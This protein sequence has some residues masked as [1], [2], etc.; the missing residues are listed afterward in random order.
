SFQVPDARGRWAA[1]EIGFFI[2]GP[3]LP[4]GVRALNAAHVERMATSGELTP[5]GEELVITRRAPAPTW[6]I[7]CSSADAGLASQ[8]VATLT[9]YDY[10]AGLAGALGRPPR[11][12]GCGGSADGRERYAWLGEDFKQRVFRAPQPQVRTTE[13][14]AVQARP[15]APSTGRGAVV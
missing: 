4:G 12:L 8:I 13:V 9:P 1:G 5:N 7:G 11:S 2:D 10:Q 3:G 6:F 15:T 14:P